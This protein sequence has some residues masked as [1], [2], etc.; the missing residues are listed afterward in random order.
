ME[1][2]WLAQDAPTALVLA[3]P[4]V[5]VAAGT[6]SQRPSGRKLKPQGRIEAHQGIQVL[7]GKRCCQPL[8]A[9]IGLGFHGHQFWARSP[10]FGSRAG[11]FSRVLVQPFRN[12]ASQPTIPSPLFRIKTTNPCRTPGSGCQS[13]M[14]LD[15]SRHPCLSWF[16]SGHDSGRQANVTSESAHQRSPAAS[17]ADN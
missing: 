3:N 7:L 9:R 16:A 6:F 11:L 2:A 8:D 15:Q 1:R 14:G 17:T 4:R 5:Q 10:R 12:T 13:T